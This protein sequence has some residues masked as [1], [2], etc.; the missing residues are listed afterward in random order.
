MFA[1]PAIAIPADAMS[2][3]PS[4][5]RS[6]VSEKVNRRRVMVN[7]FEA[8]SAYAAITMVKLSWALAGDGLKLL[9]Y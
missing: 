4:I 5:K 2:D 3:I 9:G 1:G 8:L 7:M 6:N